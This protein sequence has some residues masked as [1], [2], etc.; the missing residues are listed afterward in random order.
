MLYFP[1]VFFEIIYP[2]DS[3]EIAPDEDIAAGKASGK[4]AQNNYSLVIRF[5]HGD[6]S[7]LFT[8]D[9][10]REVEYEMVRRNFNL[11]SDI[12]KI[13]HHGSKTSSSEL[14]LE[15][16]RPEVA[17]ISAGRN[18]LYGHPHAAIL[19]RLADYGIAIRRTD[20]ERDILILSN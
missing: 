15:E 20:T 11:R 8:G 17:V 10:E 5:V 3:L 12:L 13:P 19:Q 4:L 14:F 2:F 1:I 6:K 9:I 7:F 16:V 18:N